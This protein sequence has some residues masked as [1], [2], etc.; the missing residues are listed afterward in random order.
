MTRLVVFLLACISLAGQSLNDQDLLLGFNTHN[1][2]LQ[3]TSLVPPSEMV[4]NVETVYRN[5]VQTPTYSAGASIPPLL[6]VL[7]SSDINAYATAGGRLYVNRGLYESVG[8]TPGV[9]AFVIGHE[10]VHNRNQHGVNRYFRAVQGDYTIRQA[11]RQNTWAGIAA[12]TAH[13]ILEAKLQRNEEHEADTLGMLI[14]AEAG[15]HPDFAIVAARHLRM[16]V[17]E[18]SKFAAFFQGHPR[19]TTR[20]QRSE[21]I[22]DRALAIFNSRW[23]D[24]ASSPGGEP[25]TLAVVDDWSVIKAK[26][27]IGVSFAAEVRNVKDKPVF[28]TAWLVRDK[29]T[30]NVSLGEKTYLT[31][32]EE[33]WHF[34]VDKKPKDKFGKRYVKVVAKMGDQILWESEPKKVD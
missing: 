21:G 27:S 5:M 11:Y 32:T 15:Y 10:M 2:I 9:L 13:K 33:K 19:W 31:S 6:F 20:E 25:P 16:E 17:G 26:E 12:Q 8:G 3:R 7:D 28:V 14:A 29:P 1:A 4:S 22:R 23:P 18:S 34:T 30:P 24:A